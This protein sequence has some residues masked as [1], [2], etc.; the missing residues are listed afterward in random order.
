MIPFEY[1]IWTA[2]EC[3]DYLRESKERF[4]RNTRHMGG[5]PAPVSVANKRP[6][7]RAQEVTD[8]LLAGKPGNRPTP[9]RQQ[10]LVA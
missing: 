3:A 7:W 10:K 9:L 8:W 4:L 1:V 5:F 6:R 2:D